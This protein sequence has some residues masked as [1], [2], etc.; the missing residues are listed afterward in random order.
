LFH[1]TLQITTGSS[2]HGYSMLGGDFGTGDYDVNP[3]KAGPLSE[4][5]FDHAIVWFPWDQGWTGGVVAGPQAAD[6]VVI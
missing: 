3:G 2:G 4:A 1:G 6:P 5:N